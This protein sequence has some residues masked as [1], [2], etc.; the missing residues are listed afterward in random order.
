[1]TGVEKPRANHGA[2]RGYARSFAYVRVF[3]IDDIDRG[4]PD[5][6][7]SEGGGVQTIYSRR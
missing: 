5:V 1:M 4:A 7:V 2:V 6:T 3:L